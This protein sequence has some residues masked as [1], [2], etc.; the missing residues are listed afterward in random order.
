MKRRL[1]LKKGLPSYVSGISYHPNTMV[2]EVTHANATKVTYGKDPND[3]ARPPRSPCSAPPATSHPLADRRLRLRRRGEHQDHR[4]RLVHLRQGE[5]P[6]RRHDRRG[7]QAPVRLS[8]NAFGTMTASATGTTTARHRPSASTR[9]TNRLDEPGQLRR[10]RQHDRLG[11][12]TPTP[13]TASTRC[14]PPPDR[15]QPHLRLHRRRRAGARPQQPRRHP[16]ALRSADLSG[17][18]LREYA[19]TGGGTWSW[20]KD[21]VYR[22]GQLV[23]TV[24]PPATRHIAP[25]PPRDPRRRD[26]RHAEP[27]VD[28][29]P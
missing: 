9:A 10:R 5:P 21:Y 2:N 17:K 4:L 29:A 20:S 12:D 8:Y 18:V 6:D 13:G 16:D 26:H 27:A 19:P 7:H 25:R 24:T 15:H 14:S 3:M 22:D 1:A 11:R 23:A 28:R